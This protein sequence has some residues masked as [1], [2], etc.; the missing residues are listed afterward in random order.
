MG[1]PGEG[2][3][4]WAPGKGRHEY[5]KLRN[6]NMLERV[7]SGTVWGREDTPE[8][9]NSFVTER[10]TKDDRITET[11]REMRTTTVLATQGRE[12]LPSPGQ[13][14]LRGNYW[15]LAEEPRH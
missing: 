11:Q 4:A 7:P 2:G 9:S 3:W 14:Q 8:Q 12:P 5:H 13:G 15:N 1:D 6:G 10:H